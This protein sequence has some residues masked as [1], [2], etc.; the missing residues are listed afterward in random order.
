MTRKDTILIAVVIN[1][2]LLAILFITAVIYDTEKELPPA[3]FIAELPDHPSTGTSSPVAAGIQIEVGE[4][5]VRYYPSLTSSP[6]IADHS[7]DSREAYLSDFLSVPRGISVD[8]EEEGRSN[9]SGQER[10]V[11]VKVKKGDV[12]EKIARLHNTT[13]GAIKKANHLESEHLSIGQV[14]KIPVKTAAVAEFSSPQK[15]GVRQDAAKPEL[16]KESVSPE[17]VYYTIKSGDN[18]WK[19]AKQFNV[20][21]EDILRLNGLNE[22]KART[23]KIGDRIRIK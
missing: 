16:P 19:V 1:A 6:S 23:L 11:E 12:L 13:V 22:E 3:E 18:P 20:K 8:E 5:E 10:W 2:G 15:T 17:A 21:Y 9:L 14:L 4:S 7:Q